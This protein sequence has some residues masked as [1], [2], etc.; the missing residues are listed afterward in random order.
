MSELSRRTFFATAESAA[1]IPA[2]GSSSAQESE[3]A[4]TAITPFRIDVSDEAI[5]DLKERLA[6]AR[7]PCPGHRRLEPRPAGRTSSRN[8]PTSGSTTT[9][10]GRTRRSST[11]IRI[12]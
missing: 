5:A 7:W 9:T 4:M 3:S 12:S 6:M 2:F 11:A 10:G 8:S 1:A